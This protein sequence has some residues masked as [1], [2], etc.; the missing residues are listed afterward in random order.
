MNKSGIN[1]TLW[2]SGLLTGALVGAYLYKN[3][4]DF[5][6]QKKKLDKLIGD[7]KDILGDLKTKM[8]EAKSEGLEATKT[9]LL[10][11]KDKVDKVK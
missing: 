6:P 2:L 3:K 10:S 8:I 7:V 4:D 1:K 11:A 5:G 9:A